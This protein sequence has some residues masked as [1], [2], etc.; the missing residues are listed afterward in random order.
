MGSNNDTEKP[1]RQNLAWTHGVVPRCCC[2]AHHPHRSQDKLMLLQDGQII[3][4]LMIDNLEEIQNVLEKRKQRQ[5]KLYDKKLIN[6]KG[7]ESKILPLSCDISD[8]DEVVENND[9]S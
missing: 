2:A 4:R 1:I 8:I 3:N 5:Q 9:N 7:N 6:S